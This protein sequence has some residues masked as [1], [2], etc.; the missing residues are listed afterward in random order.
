[1]MQQQKRILVLGGGFG[2]VYTARCLEKL[3]PPGVAGVADRL[4]RGW[5]TLQ[6]PTRV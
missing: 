5:V 4:G 1:M 2:G 6:W 3:L